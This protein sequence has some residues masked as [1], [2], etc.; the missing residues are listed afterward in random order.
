MEALGLPQYQAS[1]HLSVLK[2]AGLATCQRRGTWMYY[3]L[4]IETPGNKALFEF[5]EN[6]L[7]TFYSEGAF[8]KDIKRLR[9]HIC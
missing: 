4:D 3:S 7:Q 1:R 5:L 8:A 2:N 6:W 9:K